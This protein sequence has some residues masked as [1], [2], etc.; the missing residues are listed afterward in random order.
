[1]E[2]TKTLSFAMRIAAAILCTALF[3]SVSAQTDPEEIGYTTLFKSNY[4]HPASTFD[5]FESGLATTYRIPGLACT[6]DGK[7]LVAVCDER[8]TGWQDI[9]L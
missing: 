9:R 1:M 4:T 6:A 3:V 7:H 5:N 8:I 2:K